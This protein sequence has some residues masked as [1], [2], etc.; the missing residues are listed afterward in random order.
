MSAEMVQTI[1]RRMGTDLGVRIIRRLVLYL[2]YLLPPGDPVSVLQGVLD[3][4]VAVQRDHAEAQYGG[5][6]A[7]HVTAEGDQSD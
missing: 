5:R 4:D 3:P 2:G 7:H 1:R 6:G